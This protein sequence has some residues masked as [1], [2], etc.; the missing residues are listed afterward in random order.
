EK[1]IMNKHFG[2]YPTIYVNFR[3][4]QAD[5]YEG[6]LD[7]LRIVLYE[8]FQKH[9]Y[10][11]KSDL[12]NR[13]GFNKEVFM[14]YYDDV[15]VNSL[16]LRQVEYGLKKLSQYLCEHYG[17]QVYVFIDEFD[18]PVNSMVYD[19]KMKDDDRE[20]VIQLIGLMISN[21]VKD[22]VFV[23]RSLS[24]ACHQLG[25]ILLGSANNVKISRFLQD[26]SFAEFYGFEQTEVRSILEKAGRAEYFDVVKRMY[27]GY[28]TK[29]TDGK[30]IEIYSPWSIL[31][32]IYFKNFENY[33]AAYIPSKIKSQIGHP[34]IRLKLKD[35]LSGYSV[36]IV[37]IPKF[38][39]IEIQKLIAIVN[40]SELDT[41][42]VDL[43]VQ[44]LYEL[45]FFRITKKEN[46]DLW[47]D[48][49]N[50]SVRNEIDS[51]IHKYDSVKAFYNHST[52]SINDLIE[53]VKHVGESRDE[54][55]VRDLAKSIEA[56]FKA[57][58]M[59]VT[60][61]MDVHETLDVY[62]RQHFLYV[63]NE[64]YTSGDKKCDTILFD[65][66]RKVVIVF[67]WKF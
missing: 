17:K 50:D 27:D 43:F 2:K 28:K 61:E 57:G 9:P 53:S 10:L 33:W 18:V 23:E 29:S 16:S 7:R 65:K 38:E 14:E 24:N 46:N 1:E 19:N 45:G 55:S 64:C 52:E 67:E 32:C 37:S 51:Y 34:K 36:K 4:V 15:K 40:I 48:I 42:D 66:E 44:F 21:L 31:N 47:L 60:K 63:A 26:N 25:G 30:D 6:V 35:M 62:M 39:S 56:L 8:A 54:N 3:S 59:P 41:S 13:E 58:T 49:P 5:D 11:L 20:K 12:W 22:N